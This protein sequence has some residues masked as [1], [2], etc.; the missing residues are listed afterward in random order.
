[1]TRVDFIPE[2]LDEVVAIT[3]GLL[4]IKA[5]SVEDLVDHAAADAAAADL[6][7]L[8]PSDATEVRV[9]AAGLAAVTEEDAILIGAGGGPHAQ[10]G[11][12]DVL[13]GPLDPG[14]LLRGD[15]GLDLVGDHA[16]WPEVGAAGASDRA[17]GV[18]AKGELRDTE[19]KGHE[20]RRAQEDITVQDRHPVD[21]LEGDK[22]L[23]RVA[24]EVDQRAARLPQ[25]RGVVRLDG[26]VGPPRRPLNARRSGGTVLTSNEPATKNQGRT[27]PGVHRSIV[28]ADSLERHPCP[29]AMMRI[30]RPLSSL[31]LALIVGCSS[32]TSSTNGVSIP[33]AAPAPPP[34]SASARPVGS[35]QPQAPTAEGKVLWVHE[36]RVDCEGDGPRKCMKIKENEGGEW[37]LFYSSIEGFT[38]EAGFR[39]RIR[40][41][42]TPASKPAADAPSRRY[43]L[44]EVLSK[45]RP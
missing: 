4:V 42:E 15:R 39:Y 12:V 11:L 38:H 45:E 35:S 25:R 36:E 7:L 29:R 6:D 16:P 13:H 9:T 33:S 17:L 20:G 24:G 3:A 34:P 37:Q 43:R 5:G 41:S 1:M 18:A 19:A 2:N 22:L 40:V 32:P 23:Q 8:G 26:A 10:G 31:A 44:L 14:D 27:E 30:M 28:P 21:H